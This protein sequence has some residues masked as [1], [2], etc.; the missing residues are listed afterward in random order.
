MPL[1]TYTFYKGLNSKSY[2]DYI[3]GVAVQETVTLQGLY[4]SGNPN[5]YCGNVR[6]EYYLYCDSA[7]DCGSINIQVEVDGEA[8]TNVNKDITLN[9]LQSYTLDSKAFTT[10]NP[11]GQFAYASYSGAVSGSGG[12]LS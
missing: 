12:H 8:G 10:T 2:G 3:N 5:Y 9:S 6:G 7:D 11:T 1:C 4:D